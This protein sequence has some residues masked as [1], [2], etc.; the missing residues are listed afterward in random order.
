LLCRGS[1]ANYLV[2]RP[3]SA[4]YRAP[5]LRSG[6]GAVS[7]LLLLLGCVLCPLPMLQDPL[8]VEAGRI[9]R[10]CWQRTP[11]SPGAA[12]PRAPLVSC[13]LRTRPDGP[14][15][16]SAL[17]LRRRADQTP[18]A[19]RIPSTSCARTQNTEKGKPKSHE[20]QHKL[21][22]S[23]SPEG[24]RREGPPFPSNPW[25]KIS[26]FHHKILTPREE[27][28]RDRE[29]KNARTRRGGVMHR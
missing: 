3:A 12:R 2:T 27:E 24:T 26:N 8:P 4:N 5:C 19:T 22:Q 21:T 15:G 11:A 10:R 29:E 14:A 20:N 1:L 23:K 6:G 18:S 13:L 17:A 16:R 28:K 7:L 25:Y 9:C